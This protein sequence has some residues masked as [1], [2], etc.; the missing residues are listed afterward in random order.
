[1]FRLFRVI[2]KHTI[3]FFLKISLGEVVMVA[4]ESF[5]QQQVRRRK[6]L[7]NFFKPR[8]LFIAMKL[9]Q[10]GAHS[11]IITYCVMSI[12]LF[13]SAKLPNILGY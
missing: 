9:L 13:T 8:M 3:Y 5:C 10:S 1:M 2:Q 6:F 12:Q 7:I 11:F 4:N